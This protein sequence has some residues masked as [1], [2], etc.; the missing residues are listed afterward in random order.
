MYK[1]FYEVY[2]F[3]PGHQYK[4]MGSAVDLL[5]SPCVYEA[6]ACCCLLVAHESEHLLVESATAG[7]LVTDDGGVDG[8]YISGVD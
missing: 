6:D 8:Y 7:S 4:N 5:R 1:G 3:F 2:R